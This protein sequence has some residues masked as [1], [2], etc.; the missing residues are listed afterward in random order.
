MEENRADADMNDHNSPIK[1][2][3][4]HSLVC[5]LLWCLC[6]D[7]MLTGLLVQNPQG[8]LQC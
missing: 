2:R 3:A 5:L 6:S 1:A 8:L 4:V 7:T